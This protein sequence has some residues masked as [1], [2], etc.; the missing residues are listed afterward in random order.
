MSLTTRRRTGRSR[1]R[2]ASGPT[3]GRLRDLRLR[4]RDFDAGALS[5]R[6]ASAVFLVAGILGL[7]V[8][9]LTPPA[10]AGGTAIPAVVAAVGFGIIG[11]VA[12]WPRWDRRAQLA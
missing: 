4:W 5:P 12:P 7:C 2:P 1:R 6:I 3:V 9:A 8:N 11:V 10:A